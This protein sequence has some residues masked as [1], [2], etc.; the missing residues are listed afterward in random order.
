MGASEKGNAGKAGKGN[1]A[2][3]LYIIIAIKLIKGVL[4]LLLGL[5]VYRLSDNNLPAEFHQTLEF[6]HLDPEKKFFTL[7]ADKISEITPA[8]IIWLARGTVLYSLFSL[9][10]AVGLMFR[11]S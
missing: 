11:V 5:G 3:T 2:P 10:E 9:V 6:F 7:L 4:M 8:N 1:R